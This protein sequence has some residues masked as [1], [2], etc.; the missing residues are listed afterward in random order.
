M[1]AHLT[2]PYNW[3]DCDNS[4]TCQELL[5]LE[6]DAETANNY[7]KE[8]VAL[9][10]NCLL[11][12]DIIKFYDGNGQFHR[13]DGPAIIGNDGWVEWWLNGQHHR[14]DGPAVKYRDGSKEWWLN[15]KLHRLDGPAKDYAD[16]SKEWRRNGELHRVDGPARIDATGAMEWYQDGKLHREDGP[17]QM[18]SNGEKQWWTH[19]EFQHKTTEQ[20]PSTTKNRK[21]HKSW[22]KKILHLST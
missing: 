9:L 14:E 13:E 19:G 18:L 16:G 10:F 11:S 1:T 4:G 3:V 12:E 22:F 7:P 5:H 17:A 6:D 8:W 2:L 21:K 15:G 20:T